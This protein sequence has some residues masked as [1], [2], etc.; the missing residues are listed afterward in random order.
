MYKQG[1]EYYFKI[2]EEVTAAS[3]V[4][5]VNENSH[6]FMVLDP[7]PIRMALDSSN[8]INH[9]TLLVFKTYKS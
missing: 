5:W 1:K 4:E 7:L 9:R 8:I 6:L 3:I 2:S